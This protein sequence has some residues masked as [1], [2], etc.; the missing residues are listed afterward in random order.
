M[1]PPFRLGVGG[2]LGHGRQYMSWIAMDDAVSG[3]MH[4]LFGSEL[5][6]PVNLTAPQPVT[7]R[8]FTATLGRA[9]GRPT[10]IPVP[11]LALKVIFG[12]LAEATLLGGQRVIPARLQESGFEFTHDTLA[13]ALRHMLADT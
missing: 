12:E 2:R 9:V 13:G 10:V 7:N 5:A 6:G 8:D 1:L 11:A 3:I 4:C